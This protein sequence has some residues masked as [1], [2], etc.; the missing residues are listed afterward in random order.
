[1]LYQDVGSAAKQNALFVVSKDSLCYQTYPSGGHTFHA[2]TTS[3]N[4][5][6]PFS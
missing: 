6:I 1:M 5:K 3:Y 4:I 2:E